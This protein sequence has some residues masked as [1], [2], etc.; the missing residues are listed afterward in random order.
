[1]TVHLTQLLS[2]C[3]TAN[4]IEKHLS[5]RRFCSYF[6]ITLAQSIIKTNPFTCLHFLQAVCLVHTLKWS[7]CFAP[8]GVNQYLHMEGG[9]SCKSKQQQFIH[10]FKTF[11]YFK[12]FKKTQHI[13]VYQN[14]KPF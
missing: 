5:W 10:L 7:G 8:T 14:D 6:M 1:M 3:L 12:R 2:K 13:M 9:R 11:S 4:V